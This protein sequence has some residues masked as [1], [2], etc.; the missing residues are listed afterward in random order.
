MSGSPISRCQIPSVRLLRHLHRQSG[1]TVKRTTSLPE[2]NALALHPILESAVDRLK[3]T[4]GLC[5]AKTHIAIATGQSSVQTV[6]I[7]GEVDHLAKTEHIRNPGAKTQV[8]NGK[9]RDKTRTTG[10][11]AMRV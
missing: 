9:R 8:S 5:N 1:L 7:G 4:T 6:E 10:A 2:K 11:I 3:T